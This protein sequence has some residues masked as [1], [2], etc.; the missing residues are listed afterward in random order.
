MLTDSDNKSGEQN[1]TG[2]RMANMASPPAHQSHGAEP[3]MDTDEADTQSLMRIAE[4]GLD[5]AGIGQVS[6]GA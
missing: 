5:P 3:V 4:S 6:C 1:V 2:S